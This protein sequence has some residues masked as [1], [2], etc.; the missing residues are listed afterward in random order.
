MGLA[1]VAEKG[2]F[3]GTQSWLM[4]GHEPSPESVVFRQNL[5]K[6]LA[7]LRRV[8]PRVPFFKLAVHTVPTQWGL[9]R[10][11]LRAAPTDNVHLLCSLYYP[12]DLQH[13]SSF[14]LGCCLDK[15]STKLV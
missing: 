3:D 14:G 2:N 5:A 12:I 4:H 7:P 6:L 8:R 10:G 11:L 1:L 13:R 9:Y 15:T